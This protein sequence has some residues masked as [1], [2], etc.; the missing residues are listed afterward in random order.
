MK[1]RNNENEEGELNKDKIFSLSSN[2]ITVVTNSGLKLAAVGLDKNF[3][4]NLLIYEMELEDEFSMEKLYE[5]IKQYSLA[6][7]YYLQTDQ[8]KAKAYQNR[9]EYL[10]TNKDTLVQL[11]RQ[12]D[13]KNNNNDNNNND[14][15]KPNNK[16]K[17]HL[18][19]KKEEI[20][21]R[22]DDINIKDISEK[23]NKFLIS[24][25]QKEE[26]KISGKNIIYEDLEKQ[27]LNWKEKLKAK[28]RGNNRFSSKTT[29][30]GMKKKFQTAVK[31]DLNL[32]PLSSSEA[33]KNEDN[34]NEKSEKVSEFKNVYEELY[35]KNEDF[36]LEEIDKNEDSLD[37]IEEIKEDIKE[38]D[39]IENSKQNKEN[40]IIEKDKDKENNIE[41]NNKNE[42]KEELVNSEDKKENIQEKEE[43]EIK[44]KED[45]KK[46][47]EENIIKEEKSEEDSKNSEQEEYE[48][49]KN[50]IKEENLKENK[51]QNDIKK[52]S[53]DKEIK[54][55]KDDKEKNSPENNDQSPFQELLQVHRRM[56]II[57]EDLLNKINTD[58][59][60][61]TSIESQ[62]TSLQNIITNLN[63]KNTSQNEIDNEDEEESETSNSNS[64]LIQIKT[65]NN[66]NSSNNLD[67]IPAKFQGTYMDVGTIIGEY[68]NDF[69][70]FF[71]KEIFEQF[72][73]ELKELYEQK[74][75]KYI[76]IRN[77]YHN[78]IKENEY[79]LEIDDNLTKEKKEEIQQTI[80]S[81]NEEQQH[82][83]D[84]VEDEFNQ[85]ISDK[86]SEFKLKGFKH[87]SGIQLLEEKVKL[88]IY[89][90]I[91]ESFY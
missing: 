11:K 46:E 76:E 56:S 12:N 43:K 4:E 90:L 65:K 64:N 62:I 59:D 60:I 29:V 70:H 77:E 37:R 16:L 51:I 66:N 89:S 73:S 6:I 88:D 44:E 34:K 32:S 25:N 79:L 54:S 69:N 9:M 30:G 71:Y 36:K 55:P 72:S 5:L 39:N 68:M 41:E 47:K 27:N 45:E 50:E 91:N 20:K 24:S 15:N 83:I 42:I 85:K 87:N 8:S 61:S 67:K 33:I 7:E 22:Q 35:E 2:Q 21:I 26:N 1:N 84:V 48:D 3:F 58:E 40:E 57:D 28:K 74:Y 78:Q 53:L 52:I 63:K 75:K 38:D 18:N 31:S 19:S 49:L 81:L 10:L 86:I 23:V 80:E 14:K 13:K 82:Q 17:S